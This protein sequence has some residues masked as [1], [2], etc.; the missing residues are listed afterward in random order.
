MCSIQGC[1]VTE[2]WPWQERRGHPARW[3]QELHDQVRQRPVDGSTP[4]LG[5]SRAYNEVRNGHTSKL[6]QY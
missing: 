4:V 6:E 5:A 1:E 2:H 3:Y